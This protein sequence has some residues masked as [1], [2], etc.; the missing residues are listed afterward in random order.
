MAG[1]AYVISS[2]FNNLFFL[3]YESQKGNS[4]HSVHF[5]G[6]RVRA[7]DKWTSYD[8]L[9]SSHFLGKWSLALRFIPCYRLCLCKLIR[10][11]ASL[12]TFSC[13]GIRCC[14]VSRRVRGALASTGAFLV[15]DGFR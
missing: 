2:L 3:K 10:S 6:N 15:L 1:D 14:T 11:S 13:C 12:E 5:F 7:N 9:A 8:V 4:I